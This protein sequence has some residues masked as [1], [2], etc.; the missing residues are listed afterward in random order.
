MRT[1]AIVALGLAAYSVFLVATIPAGYVGSQVQST[2]PGRVEVTEARGTLWNGSAQ[3]RFA[4][5]RGTVVQIDRVEWRFLPMRLFAGEIAFQAHA[6]ATGLD[7]TAQIAR[8]FSSWHARTVKVDGDAAGIATLFP[9]AAAWR[10]AGSLSIAAP[11]IS[12]RGSEVTGTLDAEWRNAVTALS[13]VRPLGSFH[14]A[15]R[16]EGKAASFEVTTTKG[17]LRITGKGTTLPRFVFSGEARAEAE[18]A[19]ALDP[20]LDLMGP[21]RP[22]GARVLELRL[23]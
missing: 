6:T 1:S 10:P 23:N 21:R 13:D 20:L 11:E 16:G 22:D 15:W 5:P 12:L 14:A 17:P 8:G 3:V 18:A 7:G 9:L 19:K 2:M 4:P